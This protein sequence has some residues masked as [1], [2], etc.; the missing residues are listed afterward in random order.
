MVM[1][2]PL[3]FESVE[4]LEKA[5]KAYF[6]SCIYETPDSAKKRETPKPFTI[7]GLALALDTSRQTLMNYEV[8]E[9]FF[10]TIKRAKLRVENYAEERLFSDKPTGPIFAL[11][12]FGWKDSKDVNLNET[13]VTRTKKRFDGE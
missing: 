13:T 2:R 11:K 10:D 8:R 4:V 3:K 6:D 5:C 7:T 9:D 1:G 12:N